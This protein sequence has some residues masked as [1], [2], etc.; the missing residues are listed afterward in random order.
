MADI[1]DKLISHLRTQ[2]PELPH[3]RLAF[4]EAMVRAEMGGCDGGYI[5]R[6]PAMQRQVAIG[7]QLAAGATLS[8]AFQAAGVSRRHG[9]RLAGKPLRAKR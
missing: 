1:L 9:Y 8:Q 5:A 7:Q 6:R 2:M 4:A 3:E